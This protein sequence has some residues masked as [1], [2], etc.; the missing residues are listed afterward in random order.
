MEFLQFPNRPRGTHTNLSDR[1]FRRQEI[2]TVRLE[3]LDE[4]ILGCCGEGGI[5]G[6][7][8]EMPGWLLGWANPSVGGTVPQLASGTAP[9][10]EVA[11][12]GDRG[13][14]TRIDPP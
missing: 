9:G 7:T 14:G 6:R 8:G 13:L 2:P 3:D 4:P 12:A 5:A 11:H 10:R 1:Q